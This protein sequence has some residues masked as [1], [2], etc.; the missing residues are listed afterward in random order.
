MLSSS[1]SAELIRCSIV[2]CTLPFTVCTLT[3]PPS[4]ATSTRPFTV[5]ASTAAVAPRTS[6]EPF[7]VL[8]S[9]FT[10][11]ATWTVKRT[12]TSLCRSP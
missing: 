8:R 10:P 7:T 6:T 12:E 9:T 4:V 3:G 11:F 1:G 5:S 2:A